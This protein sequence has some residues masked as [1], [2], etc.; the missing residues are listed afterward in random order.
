MSAQAAP[1]VFG[2]R[3]RVVV[4]YLG[5][6]AAVMAALTLPPLGV[7][8]LLG[9]F[10]RAGRY[11]ILLGFLL[12][13]GFAAARL[14]M[15]EGVQRNEATVVSALVFV[16]APLFVTPVLAG[17]LP[18]IDVV[19]EVVS[20]LTTTGLSTLESVSDL[21]PSFLFA[22]SWMQWYGGLGV[23]ILFQA[24]LT[25]PGIVARQ[26]GGPPP[27][28]RNLVG[29]TKAYARSFAI[30]YCVLTI[31]GVVVLLLNGM[32]PF[33][34]MLHTF[35]AVSTGGFGTADESLA[36]FDWSTQLAVI[37]VCLAGACSL[38]LYHRAWRR[39]WREIAGDV[40]LRAL[41]GASA[42]VVV[43]LGVV[44][45]VVDGLTWQAAVRHA[46][47]MGLSAQTTAG[48]SN[49]TVS[50]ASPAVQLLLVAAM[51]VGG[52]VGS[53]AGGVK[54]LRALVMFQLVR[55]MIRRTSMPPHAVLIPRLDE[56][57]LEA[58]EAQ[59]ML[60][61]IALF[62]AVVFTSWLL[63]VSYGH[64]P[65]AALFEVVSATGTVGLSTGLCGPDLQTPLK[66]VLCAN[67]LF[68]R[69]EIVAF[70][71]LFHPPTWLGR[72]RKEAR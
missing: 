38:G 4:G 35:S 30:V 56:K 12:G 39:G 29:T 37:A 72:R 36:D 46:T 31:A 53:T 5:R 55:L 20:A 23:V 60:L 18:L 64:D 70:L 58:D 40:Q 2:V 68:G 19:F 63:F 25:G 26:F 71:V 28:E 21:S 41:L 17:D 65:M 62:V 44:M 33:N 54:I 22:R 11:G 14:R 66:A 3:W 27:P 61:L 49:L 7:A 52:S 67:M 50:E 48:F 1:L 47:I 8:L 34:A 16:L 69:L 32:G 59:S 45:V 13:C 15:P 9:D 10:A 57:R 6:L 43:A 24:M 42:A 51:F